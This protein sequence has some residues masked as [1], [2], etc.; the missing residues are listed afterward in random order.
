M[1]FSTR[2]SSISV[3]TSML[4]SLNTRRAASHLTK[5]EKNRI[6]EAAFK[7]LSLDDQ[8]K[9]YYNGGAKF[10]IFQEQLEEKLLSEETSIKNAKNDINEIRM[11][12]KGDVEKCYKLFKNAVYKEDVITQIA[13]S[14]AIFGMK[15]GKDETKD[16][17]KIVKK[18]LEDFSYFADDG[19]ARFNF[20]FN[21]VMKIESNWK[22]NEERG[23]KIFRLAANRGSL[24]AFLE[25]KHIEWRRNTENY[26]FAVQLRPFVSQ[27]EKPLDYCFEKMDVKPDPSCITKACTG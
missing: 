6:S 22:T 17:S 21:H 26:G 27:G 9:T 20:V 4:F 14:Q 13:L 3:R 10:S 24:T 16:F 15:W 5:F 25:L 2:I 8:V 12:L 11:I 1:H 18:N 7:N 23:F 19:F